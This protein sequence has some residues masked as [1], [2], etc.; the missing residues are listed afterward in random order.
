ML[1]RASRPLGGQR[2][3]ARLREGYEARHDLRVESLFGVHDRQIADD[4]WRQWN[5]NQL[6]EADFL[7][8]RRLRDD[9][10]SE[11]R[12]NESLQSLWTAKLHHHVQ[13]IRRHAGLLEVV[14][15]DLPSSR[16]RLARDVGVLPQRSSRHGFFRRQW[17]RWRAND[18][19][20]VFAANLAHERRKMRV[21]L[22]EAEVERAFLD[23][24]LHGFGVRDEKPRYQCW[25]ARLE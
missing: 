14:V 11:T 15:G 12:G 23:P 2:G 10:K 17:V 20:L 25:K 8:D 22:D 18:L 6:R 21:A 4:S 7:H 9:C 3:Q 5:L 24:A 16:A 13:R 1:A 19:Q